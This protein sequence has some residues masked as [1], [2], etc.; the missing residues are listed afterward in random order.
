MNR[1]GSIHT[2]ECLCVIYL[3]VEK[4]GSRRFL[5]GTECVSKIYANQEP[6]TTANLIL[7]IDVSK[8]ARLTLPFVGTLSAKS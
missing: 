8:S 5:K 3:T 2:G 4:N 7:A 6:M 1:Q